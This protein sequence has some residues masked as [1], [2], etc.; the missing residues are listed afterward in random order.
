[1][2]ARELQRPLGQAELRELREFLA[3]A[4]GALSFPEAHGFL[5]GIASAP[6]TIMPSV[7]QSELLGEF[8]FASM[9]QA[10]RVVGLVMR[11]YNQ[12]VTGLTENKPFAPPSGDDDGA[13]K[14]W[15]TGYLKAA[16]MDDVWNDDE[17]GEVFLFPMAVLS[18][19]ADL[20]G[21]EDSEG[22]IIEDPAPQLRR[23]REILGATVREA[24]EYWTA[25]R[26]R[27]MT[28]PVASR[29]PK[30]GRN[31]AC[32]CGSGLKFKKCCALKE[33]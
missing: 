15:C 32:P 19:E 2:Q 14:F 11:L 7:W 25:W 33:N 27:S 26:R 6:T 28:V 16:R 5:T 4:P 3:T 21:H 22:K 10:Q 9:A 13:I 8:S 29:P 24:N 23:C 12:V 20:V 30:A 17:R 1:M 18:G 31:E